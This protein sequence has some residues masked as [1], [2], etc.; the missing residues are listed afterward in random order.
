[1]T[2]EIS[3][4]EVTDRIQFVEIIDSAYESHTLLLAILGN[5]FLTVRSIGFTYHNQRTNAS[6]PITWKYLVFH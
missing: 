5:Q 6:L 2:M 3:L 1:M 4:G